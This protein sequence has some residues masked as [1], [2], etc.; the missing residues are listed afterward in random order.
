MQI[1]WFRVLWLTHNHG[2]AFTTSQEI[3]QP[4]YFSILLSRVTSL[5]WK[6]ALCP[7]S[8][9][10]WGDPTTFPKMSQAFPAGINRTR[11]AGVKEAETP[12]GC[13]WPSEIRPSRKGKMLSCVCV[14]GGQCPL[15]LTGLL[16]VTSQPK[17]IVRGRR[18]GQHVC[19]HPFISNFPFFRFKQSPL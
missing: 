2:T 7:L 11:K 9:H 5:I 10:L 16:H 19:S 13:P 6:G 14:L 18:V 4:S 8:F 3:N 17:W 15:Q 1:P 12:P